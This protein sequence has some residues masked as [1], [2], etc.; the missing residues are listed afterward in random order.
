[1]EEIHKKI[2]LSVQFWIGRYTAETKLKAFSCNSIQFWFST[3]FGSCFVC[4]PK[5]L[6]SSLNTICSFARD[7]IN[8]NPRFSREGNHPL[9]SNKSPGRF[10]VLPRKQTR[11]ANSSSGC[12][13]CHLRL[14]VNASG[15]ERTNVSST[16]PQRPDDVILPDVNNVL[17]V[18]KIYRHRKSVRM[19]VV[20][21]IFC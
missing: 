6:F 14:T 8:F 2:L 7:P 3:V 19:Y 13:I 9:C 10:I 1:M 20:A 15:K 18:V 16:R 11:N 12:L 21:K 17:C 4:N 5:F